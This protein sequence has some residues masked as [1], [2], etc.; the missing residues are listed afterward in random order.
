MFLDVYKV[1][2]I[3]IG[4]KWDPV[5]AAYSDLTDCKKGGKHR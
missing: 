5:A 3:Y 4:K 1:F 2:Q